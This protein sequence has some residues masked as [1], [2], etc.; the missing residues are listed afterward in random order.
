MNSSLTVFI[1]STYSDLSGERE[2]VLDAIRRLQLQHDSMEFFGARANQPIET[3]IQEVLRSNILVV[4]VGHRYG[5]LVPEMDIS[6]SEAE[7]AE[8]HARQKPCLVYMRDENVPVLPKHMERDPNKL[9]L[10]EKWKQTLQERHTVATFQESNDLAVQVAADLSRTISVLEETAR[11]R[12]KAQRES[13]IP[14]MN[15]LAEL[16]KEALKAGATEN[17][18]LSSLRRSISH[19]TSGA[20]QLGP[21]VYLSYSDTDSE[22]VKQVADGLSNYGLQVWFKESGIMLQEGKGVLE[23]ERG[24]DSADFIMIFI[25]QHSMQSNW[26][27]M[28]IS[29]AIHRLISGEYGAVLLPI[30]LECADVPP[31]LRDIQWIDMTDGNVDRAV[32]QLVDLVCNHS[33]S[34]PVSEIYEPSER[35]MKVPRNKIIAILEEEKGIVG[36]SAK[37][38]GVTPK[39]LYQLLK[40]YNIQARQFR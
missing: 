22:V 3:C 14:L 12:E 9:Q 30:L 16:V 21:S 8:G 23:I 15:E 19:V 5:S 29:V 31:L 39:R 1:C 10:L 6:F 11:S 20:Q 37:R 26:C 17:A 34:T 24:L 27:K 18:L 7:Y 40:H 33:H 2:A 13:S 25:S 36:A 4:I 28:E 32:N 38:L 35:G